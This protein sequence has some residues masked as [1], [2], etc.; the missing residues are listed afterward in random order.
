MP[1]V[2]IK[3]AEIEAAEI[4]G[5]ELKSAAVAATDGAA[6]NIEGIDVEGTDA[7]AAEIDLQPVGDEITQFSDNEEIPVDHINFEF[8]QSHK[9]Q[10][11][12]RQLSV[13]NDSQC[14]QSIKNKHRRKY[15]FRL[16]LAYLDPRPFRLRNIVW[17]WLYASLALW[18]LAGVFVLAGW[19]DQSSI[20]SLGSFTG[21]IVIA[22]LNL[23]TFFYLSHDTVY[24]RSQ[25]GK[26]RL[27]ELAN[28]N[29]DT[30]SF[31]GFVNQIVVQINKSKAAKNMDQSQLLAAELKELRRLKEEKIVPEESYQKARL[32]IF[33][34]AAFK[35]A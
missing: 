10:G 20:A 23:L 15:K 8:E 7:V 30:E 14:Y 11:M 21:I 22:L 28:N 25:F 3:P 34:H 19:F 13:F 27:F 9:L 24:F 32:Q 35:A 29:P 2:N 33:K 12:L 31:R 26:I 5:V 1:E 4:E 16:D 6:I 17:K 18:V